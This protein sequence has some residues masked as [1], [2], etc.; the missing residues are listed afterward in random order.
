MWN[1]YFNAQQLFIYGFQCHW[2]DA[3]TVKTGNGFSTPL[4]GNKNAVDFTTNGTLRPQKGSTEL[5]NPANTADQAIFSKFDK[6]GFIQKEGSKFS[7]GPSKRRGSTLGSKSKRLRID[8]E[9]SIELKL[10]W[11]EAQELLRP[12]PNDIPS[13]VVIEGHE[14][15]EYEVCI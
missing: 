13:V 1:L 14:I 7:Q 2:Q 10:T 8:N 9:E 3:Q 5:R 6:A 4:E 15:E 12:P 11:E